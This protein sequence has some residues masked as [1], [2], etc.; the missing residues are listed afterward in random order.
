MVLKEKVK[1][2]L[3]GSFR[4]HFDLVKEVHTLFTN[5]GIEVIAPDI[6]E[7]VDKTDGFVH[8]QQDQSRDCRMTELLY[9]KKAAGLGPTGFSYY[10]NP[11][12]T[13]GTSSSYELAVDQLTNTR[14]FFMKPLR[15]H[16]AYIPHNSIWKPERFIE[17]IQKQGHY[18]PP[19]IPR[20]EREIHHLAQELILP[21]STIAVGAIIVD[22]SSKKYCSGQER[23]I[24]MV[25]THKWGGRFSIVGGKVQRKERLADALRRE[26]KEET[27]LE[28]AIKE[29]ICTFDEL[30]GSGYFIPDAHRVFTDNVVAVGRRRVTL[31]EE[32]EDYVWMPPRA[33]LRD[34]NLEPNAR[35]TVE[36]YRQRH[37]Q[38]A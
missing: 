15:D 35:I 31:N 28:A 22:H 3:H 21:G 14:Y 24:L 32:A 7:I 17:Y 29:S 9:L 34:L 16:P 38:V 1:C 6:S 4:K 25:R 19:K 12:G 5:A 36:Q 27:N 10:I 37:V 11:K 18:P 13:L 20:N 2:V 23:D 30:R 26:V 8:L 33:V